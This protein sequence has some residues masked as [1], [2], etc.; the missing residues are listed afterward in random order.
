MA[1]EQ[2]MPLSSRSSMLTSDDL[3]QN[4]VVAGSLLLD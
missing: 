4:D 3:L 2:I 1:A